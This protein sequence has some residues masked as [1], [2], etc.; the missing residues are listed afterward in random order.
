MIP[1]QIT[2][3]L[4][5]EHN[6]D[7]V[8]FTSVTGGCIN[9]CF[10]INTSLKS[11]FLKWNDALRFPN[12]FENEA[13]GLRLLAEHSLFTIPV[14]F[15]VGT[16][17]EISWLLMEYIESSSPSYNFWQKLAEKLAHLHQNSSSSFGLNHSNYIGSLKQ[18]NTQMT[19]WSDF[20]ITQRIIPQLK[21]AI[22]SGKLDGKIQINFEKL[23]TSLPNLIPKEPPSLL[24]GDLWSGNLHANVDGD[25]CLFDPAVY[26]GHREMELAFTTLFGGF[27]KVF[28]E[29]YQQ[30][31][32]LD[33]DFES[34]IPIY[35]LY[36]L[37]VHVN[38]FGGGY[39]NQVTQIMNNY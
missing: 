7:I 12:M 33:P 39:A 8:S 34:R 4:K 15:N 32:P 18:S 19:D 14:V 30:S 10:K 6:I 13:K 35:N 24:H 16:T 26:Y 20:F 2:K 22:D 9:S 1:S 25:P 17:K 38:L 37:L 28:Y 36:P 11:F 3:Q 5:E 31:F 27:D 29:T 23:F 21:R